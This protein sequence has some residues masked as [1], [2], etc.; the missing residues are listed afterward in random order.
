VWNS[1]QVLDSVSDNYW[2]VF[3]RLQSWVLSEYLPMVKQMA[4]YS[5][6]VEKIITNAKLY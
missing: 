2:E 1:A 3:A 5:I 6:G 4:N